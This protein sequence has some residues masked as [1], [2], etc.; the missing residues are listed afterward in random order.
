MVWIRLFLIQLI[1]Y[2]YFSVKIDLLKVRNVKYK[3]YRCKCHWS[4]FDLIWYLIY[5]FDFVFTVSI[6]SWIFPTVWA[7]K[8]L[9]SFTFTSTQPLFLKKVVRMKDTFILLLLKSDETYNDW[10]VDQSINRKFCYI[11]SILY[12][13]NVSNVEFLNNNWFTPF[14]Y[15]V[16]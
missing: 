15:D 1:D 4:A 12:E 5:L 3:E 8:L 13:W 14:H 9:I 2:R 16:N 10:T 6:D 7:I 11:Y